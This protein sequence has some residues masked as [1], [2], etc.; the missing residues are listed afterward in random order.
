MS[1]RCV[2][3]SLALV[4]AALA[5]AQA[6]WPGGSGAL[7]YELPLFRNTGPSALE[8]SASPD[9]AQ[10]M[11]TTVAGKYKLISIWLRNAGTA[12]VEL[13][14]KQD[15]VELSFANKA[16]QGILDLEATDPTAWQSIPGE[17]RKLLQ[18][19]SRIEVKGYKRVAVFVQGWPEGELHSV[20]PRKITYRI[21]SLGTPIEMPHYVTAA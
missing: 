15:S 10:L 6:A 12:D 16:I 5:L 4:A 1:R 9:M 18:Y 8:A 3:T 14:S 21:R 20:V 17:I 19:P 2:L 11:A 7:T 13:S